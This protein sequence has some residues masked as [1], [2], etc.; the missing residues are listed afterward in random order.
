MS[1][2]DRFSSGSGQF[3]RIQLDDFGSIVPLI[4]DMRRMLRVH[5]KRIIAQIPA[6]L[7]VQNGSRQQMDQTSSKKWSSNQQV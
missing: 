7:Q 3:W 5:V 4:W 6:Q 1:G 2:F